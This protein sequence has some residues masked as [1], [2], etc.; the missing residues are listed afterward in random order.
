MANIL[1]VDD[2]KD[3]LILMEKI[4]KYKGYEVIT[5]DSGN[6]ALDVINSETKIDLVILDIM[7]P[8]INGWEVCRKIKSNPRV[9]SIPVVMLSA[10]FL[11]EHIKTSFE[12]GA[13]DHITK[14]VNF[15]KISDV[16]YQFVGDSGISG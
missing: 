7:M 12:V 4:L 1:V 9:S 6:K 11:E 3:V 13:D 2:E 15:Q 14:P 16:I 8:D 10:L 5:A